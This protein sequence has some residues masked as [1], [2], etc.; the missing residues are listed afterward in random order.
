M[1]YGT[2]GSQ[3]SVDPGTHRHT[4][5]AQCVS[6]SLEDN[7]L[8]LGG[9]SDL[10][11]PVLR[12]A[13]RGKILAESGLDGVEIINLCGTSQLLNEAILRTERCSES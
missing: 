3:L 12:L 8:L 1:S 13:S 6:S 10:E 4:L 2:Q 7:C 11:Q 5:A 9:Q